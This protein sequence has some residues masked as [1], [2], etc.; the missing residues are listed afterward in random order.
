MSRLTF[1]FAPRWKEELVV[2]GPGGSFILSFWMGIPTVNIPPEAEWRK[3][4]P[5]WVQP[6]WTTLYEELAVWCQ[7][8]NATLEVEKGAS[9]YGF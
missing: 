7:A 5:H 4:A 1:H 6:L 3:R 9:V 2:T 8:N